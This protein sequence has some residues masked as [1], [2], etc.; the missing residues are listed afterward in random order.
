VPFV[1]FARDRRGYEH[2][3]LID[4]SRDRGRSRV[5]YWFRTPPG[6]KVGRNPFDPETQRSIER[7][8]PDVQFDWAQIV[9]ARMPPPAPVENWREKR[10]AERAFK[11]ARAAE[12][13]ESPEPDGN[14]PVDEDALAA[15]DE[16]EG[17]G[18]E[19]PATDVDSDE[20]PDEG[21]EDDEGTQ[22]SGESPIGRESAPANVTSQSAVAA[23]SGTRRSRRR[24]RRK[25]QRPGEPQG[26]ATLPAAPNGGLDPPDPPK[27]PSNEG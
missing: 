25:G 21:A 3:Y 26:S 12:V 22:P 9:A 14:G 19:P 4:T 13:A 16:F 23:V 1:R 8:N 15:A 17:A 27:E 6:V 24:R 7:Q 2:V 5:L 11:K 18:Q 20:L 10:R